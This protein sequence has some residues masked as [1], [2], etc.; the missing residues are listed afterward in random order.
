MTGYG[1]ARGSFGSGQDLDI[2]IEIK[3]V[4]NKNFDFRLYTLLEMQN[5][6]YSINFQIEKEIRDF[7]YSHLKRGK[8]DLK[9]NFYDNRKIDFTIDKEKLTSFYSLIK[10]VKDNLNITQEINLDMIIRSVFSK[11]SNEVGIN[12]ISS[13]ES[14]ESLY[15]YSFDNPLY[16]ET[17][18]NI[19]G[20]AIRNHQDLALAEG[21]NLETFFVD[22]FT[23][24]SDNLLLIKNTIPE[25]R[26]QLYDNLKTTI[27]NLLGDDLSSETEKKIMLEVAFYMDRCDITEEIIRLESHIKNFYKYIETQKDESIGKSLNFILQEMQREANTISAKYNTSSTFN[28]ILIIKEEIERCR[29][30]V[31]NVE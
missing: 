26:N 13:G 22:S 20:E 5:K 30:Q 31:Q 27:S 25:H 24:I 7:V 18:F 21:K 8:I 28:Y 10:D 3:S 12:F 4:N 15:N 29:E 14:D 16:R 9:I 6:S 1:K 17:F 2:E 23:K 11:V 19:L